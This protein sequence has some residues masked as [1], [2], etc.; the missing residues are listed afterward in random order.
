MITGLCGMVS[1]RHFVLLSKSKEKGSSEVRESSLQHQVADELSDSLLCDVDGPG[2]NVRVS[3]GMGVSVEKNIL[4]FTFSNLSSLILT[5]LTYMLLR[6]LPTSPPSTST[7]Y[8]RGSA[9]STSPH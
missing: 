6:Q 2:I 7:S 9:L 1:F 3:M 8:L 5:V 4:S